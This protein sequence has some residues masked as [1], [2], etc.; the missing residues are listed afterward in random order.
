MTV[1]EMLARQEI[2][3]LIYRYAHAIDRRD[4]D[5]LESLF[6]PGA[7]LHYGLFDG[8]ASQLVA[9]RRASGS[10]FQ[11]TH[12]QTGNVIVRVAGDRARAQSYLSVVHRAER[13]GRLRDE[14]VRARY[15][16]RLERLGG[17]WLFAERTLVYDWAW[18]ADAD[19]DNWWDQLG[20]GCLTG[21]ERDDP[22][23]AFG[24]LGQTG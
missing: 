19:A 21:G 1:K 9:A 18:C 5:L 15:L 12:H 14:H 24:F 13:H 7:T 2:T 3:D 17:R 20:S 16:D 8:P 23:H 6:A 10:S 4:C 22:S 11:M